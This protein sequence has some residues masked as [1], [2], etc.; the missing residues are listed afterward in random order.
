MIQ[1]DNVSLEVLRRDRIR[2]RRAREGGAI[3]IISLLVVLVLTGLVL[4]MGREMRVEALIS[5]NNLASAQ[6]QAIA[7]GVREAALSVGQQLP[8][9]AEEVGEGGVY[10]LLKPDFLNED[11]QAFGLI[12]EASKI[13]INTATAQML[14]RLPNMTD[15]IA[16]AI[17]DWRDE[18][19]NVTAG[20]AESEYYL[21]L[22]DGYEAKNE[23]FETIEELLL[24]RG[25]TPRLLYGEDL[26]RNGILDDNENNG[27]DTPPVDNSDGV[28]DRGLWEYVTVYS[29]EKNE[30]ANG[31]PKV[32]VS[33]DTDS[34]QNN[35]A[36]QQ[37]QAAGGATGGAA[38]GAAGGGRGGASPTG[39]AGGDAAGGAQPAGGQA[40]GGDDPGVGSADSSEFIQMLI[41]DEVYESD[42]E[43][44]QVAAALLNGQSK[45]NILDAY[46]QSGL[47]AEQFDKALP[48]I[49]TSEDETLKGLININTA[50]RA[51][52]MTLPSLEEEDVDQLLER[53][54]E[55]L[56]EAGED[57]YGI[58]INPGI[59]WVTE[60]LDQVKAV[61]IGQ[62]LTTESFQSTAD[63]VAV[64]PEGRSYER[65][66]M[67]YD[68]TGEEPRV[69]YWKRLTHLGWPLD[70]ELLQKLR[71]GE[72]VSD[73]PRSA[74]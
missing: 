3:F 58:Q 67:V 68:T 26:N 60:A 4:V 57:E 13:N 12:E 45:Q 29:R 69:M 62:Y 30:T 74:N 39:G 49:T 19:S 35:A 17:V 22:D 16:A 21:L 31:D 11:E 72:P 53:R 7:M 28:L 38:G 42:T 61:Q 32:N 23:D 55:A 52:L 5:S 37:Q 15:E 51:I 43:A 18:D 8:A 56:S 24:V 59:T 71:D 50:P 6:A 70:P 41:D 25:V 73:L 34:S 64:S 47:T 66:R 33:G 10:W 46:Y 36:A 63:I 20:G 1:P 40:G 9:D 54:T 14:A 27:A 65:F 44:E 48:Y 2:A